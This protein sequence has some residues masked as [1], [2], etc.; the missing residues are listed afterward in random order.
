LSKSSLAPQTS[1]PFEAVESRFLIGLTFR[2]TLRDMIFSSQQRYDQGILKYP[3]HKLRRTPAYQ[4]ILGYSYKDYFEKFA[5]PY[6]RGRGIDLAAPD[7]LE[8]AGDLRTYAEGLR[9]NPNIRLIMTRNDILLANEDL[10]WLEAT[11]EA[12]R[13]TIFEKGGHLGNLANPAAQKAVLEALHD[14]KSRP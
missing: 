13:M 7:A 6:F 2:L 11:F 9:A 8:K 5:A 1:L 3:L 4:E 12:G 14:L 10:K